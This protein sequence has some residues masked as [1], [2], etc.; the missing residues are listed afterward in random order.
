MQIAGGAA[1][2]AMCAVD[3]LGMSAMLGAEVMIESVDPDT[4][5]SIT[6][7]VRGQEATANPATVVVF[8]GAEA[9]QG[10]SADTCCIYLNFFTDREVA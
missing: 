10:P 5:D 9:G 3:A 2:Y 1:A 6:V 8:I 7:T 4:G